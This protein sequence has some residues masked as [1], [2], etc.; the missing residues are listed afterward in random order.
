MGFWLFR[1]LLGG[2]NTM[3]VLSEEKPVTARFHFED[4]VRAEEQVG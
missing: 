3:D 1:L 4:S 2:S